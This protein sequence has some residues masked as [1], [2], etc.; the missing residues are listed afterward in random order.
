MKE[1]ELTNQEI[2]DRFRHSGERLQAAVQGLTPEELDTPSESGGWTLRQIIH[3]VA[4]DGDVWS[5]ILKK[6]IATPGAAVRFE[7]FPGNEA[8]A[9]GLGFERRSVEPALALVA[10]HRAF[11]AGLVADFPDAWEQSVQFLNAEGEVVGAMTV[12]EIVKML[13]EH[14]L[15]H[16]ASIEKA[17]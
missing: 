12:G 9:E 10:A 5:F 13:S 1:P 3:H 15:E 6:A 7:G 2:L 14:L 11:I 4:D 16:V 8:W 17:R